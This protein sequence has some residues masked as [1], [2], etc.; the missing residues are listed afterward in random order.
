[1]LLYE[2]KII[3]SLLEK[4]KLKIAIMKKM[5]KLDVN[6][7]DSLTDFFI[8]YIDVYHHGKEENIMFERLKKKSLSSGHRNS[9]KMLEEQHDIGRKLIEKII[10]L[11]AKY[12]KGSD[13]EFDSVIDMLSQFYNIY[14]KHAYFEDNSFFIEVMGYFTDNEKE[15]LIQDFFKFNIKMIDEKYKSL[16]EML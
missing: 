12:I 1:M 5:E 6:F 2:H 14:I 15:Q 16:I 8:T 13:Y 3:Y 9:I 10:V 11:S 7:I 4:L